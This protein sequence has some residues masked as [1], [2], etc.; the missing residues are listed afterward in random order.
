MN[1]L[2]QEVEFA[3]MRKDG[4]GICGDAFLSRKEPGGRVVSVLADGLGSGVKASILASMTATMALKFALAEGGGDFIHC[5]EIMENALPVCQTRKIGYSTYTIVDCLADGSGRVI[6]QG[7]PSFLYVRGGEL[8]EMPRRPLSPKRAEGVRR[9]WF[10]EFETK[11]GDR[12][13]FFSDGITEAGLGTARHPLGWRREGCAAFVLERVRREPDLSAR[14]ICAEVLREASH[15]EPG[16]RA[17]DDMTCAAIYF[18]RPRQAL[19][20]TGPPFDRT[21]DREYAER[22]ATYPGKKILCGGTSAEIASRALGRELM[23]DL[24]GVRGRLPPVSR[25]AG[26]DLVTEGILTLTAVVRRLEGMEGE[27]AGD[28]ADQVVEML[29]ESDVIDL[30]VGTRIN[31]AHQDPRLPVDLDIRRNL[32]RRMA[33][34]LEEK[35][36]KKVNVEFI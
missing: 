32:V 35:L 1:G 25:M 7:N 16:W 13:I 34:V 20:L 8:L 9:I 6:E 26:V 30:V 2:F 24:H 28:A 15:R 36:L 17:G 29:R 12:I 27:G 14:H 5:A 3:Q 11:P 4:Q 31:E 23:T 18:R 10:Y 19:V 21:R 33:R 22:L